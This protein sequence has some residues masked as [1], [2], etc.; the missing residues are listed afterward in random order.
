MRL[1]QREH[2]LCPCLRCLPLPTQLMH[3]G[4]I[5]RRESQAVHVRHLLRQGQRLL[6]LLHRL[7]RRAEPP[8]EKGHIGEGEH[9]RVLPIERGEGAVLLRIVERQTLLQVRTRREQLAQPEQGIPQ[10]IVRLQ[11]EGGILDALGRPQELLSQRVGGLQLGPD[12]IK[13]PQPHQDRE[14]PGRFPHLLAELACP[15][16]GAFH[17]R[18]GI[19]LERHQ[20]WTEGDL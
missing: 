7:L 19:P 13:H 5:E 6:A 14:E 16:I 1:R 18:R 3:P 8:Q 11:E 17:F 15:R 20:R 9:P 12:Q 2:L 10:G 4:R